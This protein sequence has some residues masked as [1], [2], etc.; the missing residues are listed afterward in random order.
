MCFQH[1]FVLL[2]SIYVI[3]SPIPRYSRAHFSANS[4]MRSRMCM[5]MLCGL[6]GFCN[7]AQEVIL[8]PKGRH[9]SNPEVWTEFQ[10]SKPDFQNSIDFCQCCSDESRLVTQTVTTQTV[11][12]TKIANASNSS[13]P[14]SFYSVW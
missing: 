2:H 13:S 6:L 9:P 8:E 1:C 3:E 5:P 7:G 11:T 4:E 10:N 14:K 12:Q